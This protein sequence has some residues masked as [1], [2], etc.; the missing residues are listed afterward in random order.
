MTP[1]PP[2]AHQAGCHLIVCDG[3]DGCPTP[4]ACPG[5]TCHR[6]G[7]HYRCPAKCLYDKDA[8]CNSICTCRPMTTLGSVM[9]IPGATMP[10]PTPTAQAAVEEE[11]DTIIRNFLDT[12]ARTTRDRLVS[13][14]CIWKL[15]PFIAHALTEREVAGKGLGLEEAAAFIE[16]L[17]YNCDK[18]CELPPTWMENCAKEFRGRATALCPAAPGGR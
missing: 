11:A 3:P 12:L 8:E 4:G 7:C 1:H 6:A 13:N 9:A 14:G 5:C 10:P 15:R 18:R 16:Q 17:I 2:P